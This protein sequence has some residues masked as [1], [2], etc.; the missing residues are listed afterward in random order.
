[1]RVVLNFTLEMLSDFHISNGISL[2]K[3]IDSALIRDNEGNPVIRGSSLSGLFKEASNKLLN[4]RIDGGEFV[5]RIFGTVLN[6]GHWKFSSA[7]INKRRTFHK[8]K[9]NTYVTLR[10]GVKI[11]SKKK[12]AQE[13]NLFCRELGSKSTFF[14]FSVEH[15]GNDEALVEDI[16]VLFGAARLVKHLG[17]NVNR[18][19]GKCTIKLASVYGIEDINDECLYRNLKKFLI[20]EKIDDIIAYKKED[21]S[22]ELEHNRLLVMAKTMEPILISNYGQVGN[23]ITSIDYIPGT[24]VMGIFGREFFRKY[25]NSEGE[26]YNKYVELFQSGKLR[27]SP[28]YLAEKANDNRSLFSTIP[29]PKD[30]LICK[31]TNYKNSEDEISKKHNAEVKGLSTESEIPDNCSCSTCKDKNVPLINAQG[32]IPLKTLKDDM[33]DFNSEVKFIRE[34]HV[35]MQGKDRRAVDGEL[36][37]YNCIEE[38]QYFI[39]EIIGEENL[40]KEIINLCDKKDENNGAYE[41]SANIG[42]SIRRGYG[43]TQLFLKPINIQCFNPLS[44]ERRIDGDDKVEVSLLFISDTILYDSFGRLIT[45][46]NKDFFEKLLGIPIKTVINKFISTREVRSF[47]SVTGLPRSADSAIKAGSVVGFEVDIQYKKQL[48]DK[49]KGIENKGLGYR[50][51]EGFGIIAFN[52]PIYNRNS[53]YEASRKLTENNVMWPVINNSWANNRVRT[54]IEIDLMRKFKSKKTDELKLLLEKREYRR[55]V[56]NL[57]KQYLNEQDVADGSMADYMLNKLS[58]FLTENKVLSRDKDYLKNDIPKIKDFISDIR[59]IVSK[60]LKAN[61]LETDRQLN[62]V[63]IKHSIEWFIKKIA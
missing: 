19:Y 57:M 12:K 20:D 4:I 34:T 36:F 51:N 15:I 40:L 31:Y 55:F 39:G 44:V 7:N 17:A 24:T 33:Y 63:L 38:G 10:S 62:N 26:C 13:K 46:F 8:Y 41:I 16:L 3:T 29:I 23:E 9:T 27:F 22:V 58:V 18:G 30:M 32:F 48:I 56:F 35:T 43:K 45:E 60:K 5:N 50:R 42:K 6:S 2:E 37:N 52:H 47:S 25:K 28:L 21:F 54:D 14:D 11:D 1:M 49:L 53:L 59:N 61:N